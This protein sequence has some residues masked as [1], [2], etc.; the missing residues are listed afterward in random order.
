MGLELYTPNYKQWLT[1]SW[2]GKMGTGER[3]RELSFFSDSYASGSFEFFNINTDHI[4]LMHKL[5]IQSFALA[6]V[7]E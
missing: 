4:L 5:N 7:V 6:N 1:Q 3:E 2:K